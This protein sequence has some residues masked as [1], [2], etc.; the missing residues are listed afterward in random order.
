VFLV[1]SGTVGAYKSYTAGRPVKICEYSIGSVLGLVEA[2]GVTERDTSYVVESNAGVIAIDRDSFL[3][4]ARSSIAA[5]TALNEMLCEQCAILSGEVTA[6]K[7]EAGAYSEVIPPPVPPQPKS[8]ESAPKAENANVFHESVEILPSVPA[9]EL[10]NMPG[11]WTYGMT[12]PEEYARYLTP[13]ES[14][15]PMCDFK[16]PA[17]YQL[18]GSLRV[19]ETRYDMRKLYTDFEPYWYNIWVCP[20]CYFAAMFNVFENVLPN[21]DLFARLKQLKS[22]VKFQFSTPRTVDEVILSYYM[23]IFIA[24]YYEPDPNVYAKLWL[25]LSW[26]YEDLDDAE[27]QRYAVDKSLSFYNK[28][29]YDTTVIKNAEDE[30][31]CCLVMAELNLL[32]GDRDKAIQLLWTAKANKEGPR[33]LRLKAE[34]RF[35]EL[36]Q[37]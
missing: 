8:A 5:M 19:T 21:N 11:T 4:K 22:S 3:V 9:A 13:H 29:Y 18:Q 24:D 1:I 7:K 15:C 34:R 10:L 33:I 25:Q 20:K 31:K 32:L 35:E 23:A 14:I 28:L 16:F 30:Q 26:I 2:F 37:I 27:S 36:K 6:L 12:E 17:A